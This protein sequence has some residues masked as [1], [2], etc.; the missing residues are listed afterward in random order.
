[1]L[2]SR[3]TAVAMLALATGSAAAQAPKSVDRAVA[4]WA[5]VKSMNG[6]F[7]QTITNP[8]MRTNSVANGAFAQQRPNK[9]SI[10]FNSGDAIVSDGSSL[11][12]YLKESAPGQVMKR[13]MTDEMAIPVDAGQF[14]DSP[15]TK[16]D[17][18]AKGAESVNGRAAQAVLLTP[19][20]GTSAPFAKATV[21]I[22]D[23]DAMIRQFE[24]TE[25]SGLVRRI[26]L[27]KMNVNPELSASD[28]R[29]VVPKGVKVI[30]R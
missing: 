15:A 7:E 4:A 20:K 28:F 26:R 23:A 16:F 17:I 11:W 18:V 29:F 10:R 9:L 8:L 24:V 21:W 1:M 6:T 22:D 12:V 19:K 25:Q 27:T 5:K 14:L 3:W 30:E 13:P 2:K